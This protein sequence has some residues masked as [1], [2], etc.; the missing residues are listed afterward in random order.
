MAKNGRLILGLAILLLAFAC[1]AHAFDGKRTGF[2][3]G[4]GAGVG[5]ITSHEEG[6]PAHRSRTG[7]HTTLDIGA[8]ISD[9]LLILFSGHL[10]ENKGLTPYEEVVWCEPTLIFRYYF[11]PTVG[12]FY[13]FGGPAAAIG[14]GLLMSEEVFGVAGLGVTAGGGYQFSRKFQVQIGAVLTQGNQA[15]FTSIHALA[16]L[17][18]Y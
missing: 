4:F 6:V 7:L 8:G 17:P 3:L 1:P 9:Q 18:L 2:C 10:T 5:V 15:S 11:K 16:T 14:T 13:V 12:S